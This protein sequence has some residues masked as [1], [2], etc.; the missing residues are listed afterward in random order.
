MVFTYSYSSFAFSFEINYHI[1]IDGSQTVGNKSLDILN[2]ISSEV[3]SQKKR[4][5]KVNLYGGVFGEGDVAIIKIQSVQ[6][7]NKF[8]NR[9]GQAIKYNVTDIRAIN[10]YLE[11]VLVK[12]DSDGVYNQLYVISDFI[13]EETENKPCLEL[14]GDSVNLQGLTIDKVRTQLQYSEWALLS[15]RMK[16]VYDEIIDTGKLIS[17]YSHIK[18]GYAKYSLFFIDVHKESEIDNGLNCRNIFKEF[19]YI[20]KAFSSF[21]GSKVINSFDGNLEN[22]IKKEFIS[23]SLKINEKHS[24]DISFG[25][26]KYKIPIVENDDVK[27]SQLDGIKY[28]DIFNIEKPKNIIKLDKVLDNSLSIL[29]SELI[30]IPGKP[31][32]SFKYKTSIKINNNKFLNYIFTEKGKIENFKPSLTLVRKSMKGSGK[33]CLVKQPFKM[34]ELNDY[35]LCKYDEHFSDSNKTFLKSEVSIISVWPIFQGIDFLYD[36]EVKIHE[37]DVDAEH[38]HGIEPEK[39]ELYSQLHL[40]SGVKI[41]E[42]KVKLTFEEQLSGSDYGILMSFAFMFA[43]LALITN[44]GYNIVYLGAISG[45]FNRLVVDISFEL[46]W[47]MF[48]LGGAFEGKTLAVKMLVV[49][50]VIM[51]ILLPFFY[52]INKKLI[53]KKSK[54]YDK[55]HR[56]GG[57]EVYL[58]DQIISKENVKNTSSFFIVS[59]A[60]MFVIFWL[61]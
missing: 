27:L 46:D 52:M 13:H 6:D 1:I 56:E 42:T 23:N 41:S 35:L 32:N 54:E 45:I 49:Y 14:L 16:N 44:K 15:S 53:S 17:G 8:T 21:N 11:K 61:W 57:V 7:I 51:I 9:Q 19:D 3:E 58:R 43:F 40:A 29:H 2:V 39:E 30:R 50:A 4:G 47:L 55:K 59:I 25:G 31:S 36:S 34:N 24:I 12:D 60:S 28:R 37:L 33:L 18:H 5:N 20:L 10:R 26:N 38:L 48:E 22:V